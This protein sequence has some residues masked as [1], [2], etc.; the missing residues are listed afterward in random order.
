MKTPAEVSA[1]AERLLGTHH[2]DVPRAARQ[3]IRPCDMPPPR[4][5][6][7]LFLHSATPTLRAFDIELAALLAGG[8]A[9]D[10]PTYVEARSVSLGTAD[11]LSVGRT[12]PWAEAV[13][14]WGVPSVDIGDRDHYYLSQALLAMAGAHEQGAATPLRDVIE[15][16]RD[17]PQAVVRLYALDLEMQVF[18]LWLQRQCGLSR[19]LTDANAPVIAARWNRKRPLHP[20]VTAARSIPVEGTSA[21]GLLA[22]EQRL[23]EAHRRLGLRIPVLP[24]YTVPRE[25]VSREV[26]VAQ[27]LEAAEMLR[28]RYDLSTAVLK[29]SAAGD[30]IGVVG[31]LDLT[32]TERL[33]A[34]AEAAH[35]LED[36]YLLEAWVDYLPVR[37]GETTTPLAVSGHFHF[38]QLVDGLTLQVLKGYSWQGNISLDE[39][40]W[41]ALGL[42][43]DSYRRIRE[44]LIALR[45]AF[46]GPASLREGSYRG[47]SAG[48]IDFAVGRIGGRFGDTVLTAAIDLNL[49]AHGAAGLHAFQRTARSEGA[50]HRFAA[51]RVLCPTADQ[52]LTRMA[53]TARSMPPPGGRMGALACVPRHWGMIAATGH[54]P[55]A[56]ARHVAELLDAITTQDVPAT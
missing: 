27:V 52:T 7:S 4:A 38:G 30:G 29:P 55:A 34:E 43:A 44:A 26:F 13:A 56:A 35:A 39:P 8:R 1:Y 11:D 9:H 6:P 33:T 46:R 50:V 41:R 23:S 47:L 21:V 48:G 51:T 54:D 2:S 17:H 12:A 18:L 49:S 32:D 20:T 15:W 3:R 31:G 40:S 14:H 37:L 19:L 42:P 36:D 28:H 45:E 22:A 10:I 5:C 53:A 16:L 24:G 25:G